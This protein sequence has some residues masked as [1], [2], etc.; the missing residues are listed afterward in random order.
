MRLFQLSTLGWG[1]SL[2]VVLAGNS[3]VAQPL[4][5]TPLAQPLQVSG[6]VNPTQTSNCGLLPDSPT[7][8]LQVNQDFVSLDISVT[9]SSG[10]TLLI[11]GP[12]GF[13][14]CHRAS[15]ASGAINAPGLL[16][17]GRYAFYVGNT[18]PVPTSY[19]LTIGQN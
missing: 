10:L 13:S 14:E 11:Q 18:N 8:F 4:G 1:L 6:S 3:A 15:G 12:N 5:Q 19:S 2:A 9:G 7:Q 16:S 17:Q